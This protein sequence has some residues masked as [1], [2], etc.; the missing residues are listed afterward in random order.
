[1]VPLRTVAAAA[2]IAALLAG[3]V[4]ADAVDDKDRL[5]VLG[6]VHG[7]CAHLKAALAMANLVDN[8]THAWTGGAATL[9]QMGD[10][11]DRGP[12]DKC[13]LD[14]V[15]RLRSEAEAA[16]GRVLVLLGNHELM[17]MRG[18]QHYVHADAIEAFGGKH[19]HRRSF[20][21]GEPYGDFV[22]SLPVAIV[23]KRSLFV[24]AGLLPH[25]ASRGV[26]ELNAAATAEMA[27]DERNDDV[28]GVH[29]PVWT[30]KL[31]QRAMAGDCRLVAETLSILKLERMVV[32]H[33]PQRH[34][35]IGDYCDGTLYAVDVGLSR[36]MY[37]NLALLELNTSPEGEIL[38]SEIVPARAPQAE[39]DAASEGGEPADMDAAL[40]QDP[41]ILEEILD[42][43]QQAQKWNDEL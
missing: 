42:T 1:M 27:G 30:R 3:A 10:L 5:V 26:D 19:S 28:L 16:G 29:G 9:L 33:T 35:T 11:L 39:G 6:D 36:W 21:A 13:V 38:A 17:N 24:H 23:E 22:R 14:T 12:E 25:F 32:G 31:I 8:V 7:D 34:G 2:L 20:S 43:V 37:G 41:N 4:C 15:L 18:R 40:R